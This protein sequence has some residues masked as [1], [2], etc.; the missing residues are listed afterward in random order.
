MRART[1]GLIGGVVLL[2]GAVTAVVVTTRR[3][4]WTTSSAEALAEFEQGQDAIEKVYYAEARAHFA[5]ALQLDPNFVVAKLFLARS[6]E[7]P[8]TDKRVGEILDELRRADLTKLSPRE[9]F[10]ITYAEADHRKDAAKAQEILEAYAA[11]APDDPFALEALAGRAGSRQD[12]GEAQRVYSHLMKVDPN[13]VSAYNQLGYLA[14]A[15]GRF[16]DAE[17]MFQTYRYIAPDQANPHDSLG[18]LLTLIGRYGEAEKEYEDALRTKPDFCATFQHLVQL[19]Q[20]SDQD[21]KAEDTFSRMKRAG[22]CGEYSNKAVACALAEWPL[23]N[24][25]DWE[26]AWKAALSTCTSDSAAENPIAFT[27]AV[28][29]GRRKDADDLLQ[30]V[31]AELAKLP[32]AAPSKQPLQGAELHMEGVLLLADGKPMEAADRFLAADKM[33]T[34][35][36]LGPGLFK[37]FNGMYRARALQQ[38]GVRDEAAKVIASLREVN[39][40]FVAQCGRLLNLTLPANS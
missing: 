19:Y 20:L 32:T 10:L 14:M 1:I 22:A 27:A 3:P 2:A 9:Q 8:S 34:Y 11:K 31:R 23:A 38:A 30:K 5:R 24:A 40:A 37:L 33:M 18:E 21:A 12:W 4:E 15:Q 13:R 26:G 17:K 16:A 28:T 7:L 6:L 36:E 25:L 39:P 35:R 29:T